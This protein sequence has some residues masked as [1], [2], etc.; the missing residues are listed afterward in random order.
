M[1]LASRYEQRHKS[2]Q[3]KIILQGFGRWSYMTVKKGYKDAAG[4]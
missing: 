1:V 2:E 4:I 3:R